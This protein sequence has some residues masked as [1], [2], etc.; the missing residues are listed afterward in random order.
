LIKENKIKEALENYNQCL[1]L[2]QEAED[3]QEY[4][5]VLQNQCVCYTKV[6]KYDDVLSTCIRILKLVNRMESKIL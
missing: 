2:M 4:L 1:K 5:A 6:E 3:V